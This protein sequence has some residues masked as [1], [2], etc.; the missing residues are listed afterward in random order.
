MKK[1]VSFFILLTLLFACNVNEKPEFL[2][3]QNIEVKS[4]SLNNI[5]LRAEALFLNPNDIGGRLESDS[6][7]VYVNDVLVGNVKA[8]EF[9]VPAREEFTLPL[10]ATVNAKKVFEED[11]GGVIGGV[12]NSIFKKKIKVQYKGNI[13]Y[14]ITGFSYPYEIDITEEVDIK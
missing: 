5:E 6:I 14:K 9:K 8:Q 4:I 3:V 1:I 11:Q 2:S 7:K 13:Y 12:L 10:T